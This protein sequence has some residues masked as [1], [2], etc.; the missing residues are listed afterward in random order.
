MEEMAIVWVKNDSGEAD[1]ELDWTDELAGDTI[2]ESSWS[3]EAGITL[4]NASISGTK[5]RVWIAA[6]TLNTLY[7]LTNEIVTAGGR[8]F[9]RSKYILVRKVGT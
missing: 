9:K 5:T 3:G 1:Y 2:A 7:E 4:S 8:T 6:G